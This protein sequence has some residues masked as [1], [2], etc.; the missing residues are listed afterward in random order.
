MQCNIMDIQSYRLTDTKIIRKNKIRIFII[1]INQ[2]R[3]NFPMVVNHVNPD[4]C[5]SGIIYSS[6]GIET[7][8]SGPPKNLKIMEYIFAIFTI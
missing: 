3:R 8:Q 7:S 6:V 2:V 1:I 4:I 5:L